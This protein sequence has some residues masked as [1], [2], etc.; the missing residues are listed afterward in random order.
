MDEVLHSGNRIG[1]SHNEAKLL[2]F[3]VHFCVIG[4]RNVVE[5]WTITSQEG[6]LYHPWQYIGMCLMAK[7][8]NIFNVHSHSEPYRTVLFEMACGSLN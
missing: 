4:Q 7:H 5:I 8:W 6:K 1:V 2:P 3:L